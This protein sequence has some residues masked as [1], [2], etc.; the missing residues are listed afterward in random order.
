M[1]D[2]TTLGIGREALS[3]L[4]SNI[5][6]GALGFAGTLIFARVL[7]ASGLGVYQTALAASFVFTELSSGIASAIKKRVSEVDTEAEEFLGAGLI[8]H[9]SFSIFVLLAFLVVKKPASSYFGSPEIA[10]GVI[11]VVMSLGLFQISNRMYGGIGY[12]A[13]SS[14][15]DTIR[16]AF[17]LVCQ[18]G[19]LWAGLE[20]FGLIIGLTV[21]TLITVLLTIMMAGIRPAIPTRQTLSRIYGFARWSV[22]NG[23]LKNLYS[24]SDLLIITALA[25]SASAGFYTAARQ[26]VRPSTFISSSIGNAL[27]VKSSGRHSAGREVV[28]DLLNSVAYAGLIA[29]P[30]LFGALAMPSAIPRTVFGGEF[31]AAGGAL[32]GLSFFQIF[33]VYVSQ[34]ESVFGSIDRP[35][36]IFRVNVVV[37]VVHLPLA[38]GF[39]YEYGLLGVVAATVIAELIRFAVYQYLAYLEFDRIILPRPIIEQILSAGIMLA[40]LKAVLSVIE[41]RGWFVLILLVAGGAAIYFCT[42]FI[43]S[44]HFRFALRNVIPVEFGPL[45]TPE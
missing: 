9:T 20:A 43:I 29:V 10:F 12:P 38:I 31:A 37:T 28:Q 8:I 2:T 13:R 5:V 4:I 15:M 45:K 22:P 1:R 35:D 11:A 32:I 44:S 42:L 17:T 19:L 7:G 14:W 23:L 21:G 36:T 25:S 27:Y 34:F 40:V 39:G 41:I 24:S 18:L 30:I 33:D 16:S 3:G 6:M 26:L